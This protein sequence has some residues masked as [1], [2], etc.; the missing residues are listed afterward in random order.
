MPKTV[1]HIAFFSTLHSGRGLYVAC[2]REY[3]V[4]TV[5]SLMALPAFCAPSIWRLGKNKFILVGLALLLP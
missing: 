3:S 1:A 5:A 2:V 4:R